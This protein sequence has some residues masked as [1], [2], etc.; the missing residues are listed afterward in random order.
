LL[1]AKRFL[2]VAW[3]IHVQ[4]LYRQAEIPANDLVPAIAVSATYTKHEKAE[5]PGSTPVSSTKGFRINKL[6][7][8]VQSRIRESIPG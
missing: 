2:I 1:F 3:Q 5:N 7:F 6:K 4:I 8:A